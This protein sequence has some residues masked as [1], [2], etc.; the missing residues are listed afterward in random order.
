MGYRMSNNI[1]SLI[2][3]GIRVPKTGK[4]LPSLAPVAAA[5]TAV[6]DTSFTANW[7][8]S[9]GATSYRLDVSTSN[10]FDTFVSGYENK[11]VSGTSQS[12]TGLTAGTTY[13]YRVRA[14]GAGGTSENSNPITIA[15]GYATGGI[16]KLH[17]G[18]WY[19]IFLTTAT[20]ANNFKPSAE[21]SADYLVIGGGGAGG[22]NP[23]TYM[24]G[25]GGAGAVKI[26]AATIPAS[27]ITGYDVTIG[28]GGAIASANGGD[29]TLGL[30]SA[31]VAEGGGGGG[32]TNNGNGAS[33]GSGGSGAGTGTGGAATN[34]S[35]GKAGGNGGGTSNTGASGGG[36]GYSVAG[37]S[38]TST[39]DG[40]NGGAGLDLSSVWTDV[41][42]GVISDVTVGLA[43]LFAGGGGGGGSTTQGTGTH[44]GSNAVRGTGGNTPGIPATPNT[45]G[46]AGCAINTTAAFTAKGGSGIVIVRY[47]A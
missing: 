4:L 19:H 36:G 26:G 21:L 27:A 3:V 18:K 2:G 17:A 45:G 9:A 28:A 31:I 23:G 37:S 42:N 5:A 20:G 12:V 1:L 25:A 35:Y 29:T 46:G 43:G 15:L 32:A 34:E 24:R 6:K 7:A 10:T 8:A 44:G 33:G 11:S 22:Q 41:V 38:G 47:S 14:V 30:S 13:Y 39:T 16:M 40:G